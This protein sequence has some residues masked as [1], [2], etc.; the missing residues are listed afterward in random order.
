[1]NGRCPAT[2]ADLES[3]RRTILDRID[4]PRDGDAVA[5]LTRE[6]DP[7]VGV[8]LGTIPRR[9]DSSDPFQ[10]EDRWIIQEDEDNV[11]HVPTAWI[12]QAV[13]EHLTA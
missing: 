1:V 6:G 10:R 2:D 12:R 7:I 4:M 3:D 9:H 8:Y 11:V 5:V 13:V